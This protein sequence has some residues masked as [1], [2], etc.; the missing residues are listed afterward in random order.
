[1]CPTLNALFI[2]FTHALKH[3]KTVGYQGLFDSSR[4]TKIH[5][6]SQVRLLNRVACVATRP[7]LHAPSGRMRVVRQVLRRVGSQ[8]MDM[9]EDCELEHICKCSRK[10][11]GSQIWLGQVDTIT[12]MPA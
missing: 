12:C 10:S 8:V 7:R 4:V 3:L 9:V 2:D 6:S 11:V 1:M 5:E